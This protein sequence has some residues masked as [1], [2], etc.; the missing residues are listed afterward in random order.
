MPDDTVMIRALMRNATSQDPQAIMAPNQQELLNLN[1]KVVRIRNNAPFA[2]GYTL[3]QKDNNATFLTIVSAVHM[4]GRRLEGNAPQ[5][6]QA[7]QELNVTVEQQ[8][9]P[10]PSQEE[11]AANPE[12]SQLI[13]RMAQ[14]I[15]AQYPNELKGVQQG[16]I[17]TQLSEKHFVVTCRVSSAAF[18]GDKR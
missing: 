11:L 1:D 9:R 17:L 8:I 4:D 18:N 6:Q 7:A 13:N 2:I 14:D 16:T 5:V 12:L 15:L 10:I 3:E